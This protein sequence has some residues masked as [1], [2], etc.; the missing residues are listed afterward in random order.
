[1]DPVVTLRIS[2]ESIQWLKD[3]SKQFRADPD[4][5]K[6]PDKI[7]GPSVL[8]RELIVALK[9]RRLIILSE[10]ASFS[11]TENEPIQVCLNPRS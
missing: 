2:P 7:L 1:M 4:D 9:E 3:Y 10:P 6:D 5:P 11:P 8:I